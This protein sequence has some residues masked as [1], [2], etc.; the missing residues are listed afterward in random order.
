MAIND[1]F[2]EI[3]NYLLKLKEGIQLQDKDFNELG[4]KI[5][6][7]IQK[8][9]R[10]SVDPHGNPWAPIKPR[11]K[12]GKGSVPGQ[13]LIDRGYLR[14]SLMN[15]DF[16]KRGGNTFLSFGS[17]MIYAEAHNQGLN[18]LKQRMFLP[19]PN[20]LPKNWESDIIAHIN[21]KLDNAIQRA[22]H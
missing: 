2:D 20:N 16:Y 9:F 6:R 22:S 4:V 12:K 8:G 18:G 19:D 17:N 21:L 11:R 15:F 14:K 13:P 5:V 10:N 7:K 1:P 3:D